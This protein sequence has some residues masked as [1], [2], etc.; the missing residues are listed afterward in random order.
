M[1]LV[2]AQPLINAVYGYRL[3]WLSGRFGAH[4][5]ALSFKIAE[6][7]LKDGYRLITN[8]SSIWA[9]KLEDC[10]LD[11]DGHLKAVV[12]LDEGGLYFKASK[13]VEMIASY[14]AKMSCIYMLP[15]F[16]PPN[17]AAQVVEVQPV[18]SL[19]AAG[20][21][22]VFVQWRVTL[23]GF[24]DRGFFIWWRP[25]EIYGIYSRQDPG[26]DPDDII[27]HMVEQAEKYRELFGHKKSD[28]V[29]TMGVTA[30]DLLQ[31]AA[32][33]LAQAADNFAAIPGRKNRRRR[34]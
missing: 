14:A 10:Q 25:Q 7:Y 31:D 3:V 28:G 16:W 18:V 20:V 8:A 2:N 21:P 1:G 15:S 32:N 27:L 26:A 24:K 29:S 33:T 6:E 11:E 5:T 30:E 12:L 34:I 9:D 17:R 4:K 13:Q 22:L 23:G 19:K